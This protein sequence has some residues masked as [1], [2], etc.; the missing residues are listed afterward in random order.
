MLFYYKY[1]LIFCIYL[2]SLAGNIY[3]IFT[4]VR[5][6]LTF[7]FYTFT[8]CIHTV[9]TCIVFKIIRVIFFNYK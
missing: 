9:R 5:T 6:V 1:A 4:Y 2:H 8:Y 7:L 3:F